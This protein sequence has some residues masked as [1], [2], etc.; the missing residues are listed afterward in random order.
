[1][2]IL[3]DGLILGIMM[4]LLGTM[5][6]AKDDFYSGKCQRIIKFGGY[7]VPIG[8][9]MALVGVAFVVTS[10]IRQKKG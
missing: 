6:A 4:V 8:I 1:M 9:V 2:K 7:H 3:W 5:I 10:F